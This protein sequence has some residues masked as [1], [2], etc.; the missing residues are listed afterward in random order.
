MALQ[1]SVYSLI[2]RFQKQIQKIS[3]YF[4]HDCVG[5][6]NFQ[7]CFVLNFEYT[8]QLL[9]WAFKVGRNNLNIITSPTWSGA[10]AELAKLI[11]LSNEL[12]IQKFL[13]M[14]VDKIQFVGA[15]N[16]CE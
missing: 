7:I 2:K 14:K 5:G 1:G 16:G 6:L 15:L 12:I 13:W 11:Y 4:V 8:S 3:I 9:I 10:E